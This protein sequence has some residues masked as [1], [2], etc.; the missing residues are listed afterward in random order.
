MPSSKNTFRMLSRLR[1]VNTLWSSTRLGGGGIYV[2][3]VMLH[4]LYN[5]M[6]Y[7]D[8]RSNWIMHFN[9]LH[10]V[11]AESILCCIFYLK[12][13]FNLL[14]TSNILLHSAVTLLLYSGSICLWSV[15]QYFIIIS[16]V[17]VIIV[18]IIT[19]TTTTIIFFITIIQW[20][21]ASRHC[22]VSRQPRGGIFTASASVSTPD[23]LAL[24]SVSTKLPRSCYC[25]EAPIP[26]KPI[27]LL[28]IIAFI[29]VTH[30]YE[31]NRRKNGQNTARISAEASAN[32]STDAVP[33]DVKLSKYLAAVN[34]D[35][36]CADEHPNFF[37]S[38]D[39]MSLRPLFTRLFSIPATSAP[40]ERV[41]SQGYHNATTPCTVW[42]ARCGDELLETLMYLRCNKNWA[43]GLFYETLGYLS[44]IF[45]RDFFGFWC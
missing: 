39:Y 10:R 27:L 25:L 1:M 40:V 12:L 30:K 14:W 21:G 43:P 28:Q 38:K 32:D 42:G 5:L 33:A 22:L 6:V 18:I 37:A 29:K 41:F 3:E 13:F 11:S 2:G 26:E 8:V 19:I 31:Q 34:Q 17:V 23:V 35:D 44:A 9:V 16:V 24:A 20:C 15:H 7:C 45:T 4:I 36:F